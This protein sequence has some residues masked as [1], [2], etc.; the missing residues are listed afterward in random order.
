LHVSLDFISYSE[1]M[2]VSRRQALGSMAAAP[3]AADLEPA[4]PDCCRQGA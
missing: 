3:F 1:R 4:G 2:S